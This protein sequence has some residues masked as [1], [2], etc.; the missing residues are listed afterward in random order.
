MWVF[1]SL[2]SSTHVQ[3]NISRFFQD[4][5][6]TTSD[7]PESLS[8]TIEAI[9]EMVPVAVPLP[10]FNTIFASQEATSGKM[11]EQLESLAHHY[12]NMSNALHDF[13][14]GEEFGEEDIMGAVALLFP[15][16]M[17]TD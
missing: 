2:Q 8:K 12:D 16:R 3:V 13:E 15:T 6:A 4:I 1:V 14:A 7:Y 17:S 10:S 11:A 9:K 5:L